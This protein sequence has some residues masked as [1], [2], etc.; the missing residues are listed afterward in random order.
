MP[1]V[2]VS[3]E[4]PP[5]ALLLSGTTPT[6]GR[7]LLDGGDSASWGT[8]HA[9]FGD[10]PS[11]VA[12][13]HVS[14]EIC[15]AGGALQSEV[16]RDPFALLDFL[17]EPDARDHAPAAVVC[18]LAYDLGRRIERLGPG[19]SDDLGVPLLFAATHAWI[20]VYSYESQ[21]YF[22]RSRSLSVQAL[23]D[24]ARR[25]AAQARC[26]A[27][28]EGAAPRSGIR[29]TSSFAKESYFSAVHRALEYIAAGDIY[30]VNLAQRFSAA[31]ASS[32]ASLFARLTRA[33]PAPYSA[34]IEGPQFTL[35]SNSPECFLRRAGERLH[36]FPIKGTRRR[37]DA[38][39]QDARLT[40]ELQS[41]AKEA[42]EHVMI[43]DLERNDLGR[44]CSFGTVCVPAYMRLRTLGSLHH[45]E[46]EV[47]GTLPG[48]TPWSAILRA[49]FPGGSV[50]GAPKIRA[51]QII[52]ELEP[53]AR[54]FYTGALGLL[55]S[56]E[57]GCLGMAIRTATAT[58]STIAYHSGG[59]IVADSTPESEYEETI[60]KARAFF[61][62]LEGP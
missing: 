54:R 15:V 9:F 61:S 10:E 3:L 42:A 31:F 11:A 55:E 48:T 7:F 37:G 22:L 56:R 51:M 8:G 35:V 38:P 6:P 45:L 62:A 50:T 44:L 18:A 46:S 25:L 14:G 58:D 21:R 33:H 20:L 17:L 39:E 59:A 28:P 5:V 16:P 1:E 30:Q 49:T 52:D 23:R 12:C 40:A 36:T 2:Q 34:Y 27:A 41:D 57:Q 13:Y 4:V 53:V 47:A 60:L 43:V 19:P 29:L 32:P 26:A 24:I